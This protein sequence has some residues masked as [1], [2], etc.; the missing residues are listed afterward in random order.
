MNISNRIDFLSGQKAIILGQKLFVIAHD[1]R[2]QNV[3]FVEFLVI[4]YWLSVKLVKRLSLIINGRTDEKGI[5]IL[6][7]SLK[8]TE[9]IHI[10]SVCIRTLRFFCFP[11][12]KVSIS[13][14]HSTVN[15]GIFVGSNR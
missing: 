8:G 11:C 10:G 1:L 4:F 14:G 9:I 7:V 5:L 3:I 13:L 2:L 6:L 12:I 15:S